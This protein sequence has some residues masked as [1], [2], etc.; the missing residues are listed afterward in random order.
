MA[1]VTCADCVLLSWQ[2]VKGAT[3]YHVMVSTN[4][5]ETLTVI[6]LPASITSYEN[7]LVAPNSRL[8]PGS[9][10]FVALFSE[11]ES[12]Y[13]PQAVRLKP[14]GVWGVCFVVKPFD[15]PHN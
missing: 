9:F 1:E 12:R 3:S 13:S 2:A 6:G 4:E 15:K 10:R 7:V 8:I 14:H 11:T 5:G